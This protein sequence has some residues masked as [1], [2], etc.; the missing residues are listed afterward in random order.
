MVSLGIMM[1]GDLIALLES[2]C[3]LLSLKRHHYGNPIEAHGK[4]RCKLMQHECISVQWYLYSCVCIYA[5]NFLAW[6]RE[7]FVKSI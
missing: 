7:P 2:V 5:C 4:N 3:F 1:L 6:A